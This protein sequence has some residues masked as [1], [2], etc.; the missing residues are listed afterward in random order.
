[1][2]SCTISTSDLRRPFRPLVAFAMLCMAISVS[3]QV[4]T[5]RR[6][7]IVG[8]QKTRPFIIRRE[9]TFR[10]GDS[11]LQR[12]LGQIM[13]RNRDNL[14]NLGIFNQAIVNVSEWDTK[15]NVIDVSVTVQESWY[16][17]PAPIFDLADRNFNVWWNTYNGALNRLNLGARLDWLNFTGQN[18]KLKAKVQVGYTPKQ[19]FEYRFPF[20]DRR[21]RFGITAGFYHA[22]NKEAA[23]ATVENREQFVRIDDR[24]MVERYRGFV[25]LT[26]RPT[27]LLRHEMDILYQHIDADA[28]FIADYNP[29]FFR[30][31]GTQH[32]ALTLRYT[33]E[34]DNRDIKIFAE[35]GIRAMLT[36]EKAG[37]RKGADENLFTSHALFEGNIPAGRHFQH[38][39]TFS[40][41][42]SWVRSRPSYMYYQ[43]LG[44][45]QNYLRGYELYLVD[46]LDFTLGKYQLSYTLF[47]EKIRWGAWVPMHPFRE[48]PVHVFLSFLAETGYVNDPFT[49]DVNPLANRPLAGGGI[50]VEVLLYHNL[51]F[52]FNYSVN[53][54]GER[55]FY[56]H[57]RTSF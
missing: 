6:I 4:V 16:I 32:T 19:E 33:F 38:R 11:L 24:K 9:L 1:M 28:R 54:L 3:A 43:A 21:Q 18:D 34:Y 49:G 20:L 40:A 36:L 27:I 22:S 35:K 48:M 46:G 52:D 25:R 47:D 26:Y 30:N 23:F 45:G 2:L 51:L 15:T 56:I 55:G 42:Y 50:G 37:F 13:T 39:L 29:I 17:Y 44:Y 14:L 31:G 12:D 10:E 53:H 5:V 41:K 57:N 8:A 7:D